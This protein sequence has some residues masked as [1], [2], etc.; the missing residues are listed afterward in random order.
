MRTA[1]ETCWRRWNC[2]GAHRSGHPESRSS[3]RRTRRARPPSWTRQAGSSCPQGS[4]PVCRR[5]VSPAPLVI[6]G[7]ARRRP[8]AA[9]VKLTLGRAARS[10]L[11]DLV[12]RARRPSRGAPSA[13]GRRAGTAR[14]G[15]LARGD[16]LRRT[17]GDDLHHPRTPRRKTTSCGAPSSREATCGS[18]TSAARTTTWSCTTS[19]EH[20]RMR[21]KACIRSPASAQGVWI[22]G[23]WGQ[24]RY[25]RG[26]GLP[27]SEG[28]ALR[29][30]ALTP[31]AACIRLRRVDEGWKREHRRR[32]DRRARLWMRRCSEP[33]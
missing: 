18:P 1:S 20:V 3:D 23:P 4:H 14:C 26:E 29:P 15:P 27:H 11:P 12:T 24:A 6:Q 33:T 5:R 21:R 9:C 10:Y 32:R 7:K 2:A 28:I 22:E 19:V 17:H 13:R 30:S 25:A 16:L 8:V 31:P